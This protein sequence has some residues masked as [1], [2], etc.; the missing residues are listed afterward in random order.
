MSGFIKYIV[1]I[2]TDLKI[3]IPTYIQKSTM[4]CDLWV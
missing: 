1:N 4:T 2:Q 3:F